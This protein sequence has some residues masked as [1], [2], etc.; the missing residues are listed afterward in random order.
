M[1]NFFLEETGN[2]KIISRKDWILSKI[3][4]ITV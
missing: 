2:K 1:K 3:E 4:I